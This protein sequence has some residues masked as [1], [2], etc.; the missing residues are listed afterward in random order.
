MN[1]NNPTPPA[2][3]TS[4]ISDSSGRSLLVGKAQIDASATRSAPRGAPILYEATTGVVTHITAFQ[5]A[6][7]YSGRIVAVTTAGTFSRWEESTGWGTVSAAGVIPGTIIVFFA[8]S[9][10]YLFYGVAG[11]AGSAK[12]IWRSTDHGATW[13]SVL[14]FGGADDYPSPI[15]ED[16]AGNLYAGAYGAGAS[17]AASNSRSLWKSTDGGANWSDISA[18]M[19]GGSAGIDRHIHGVWW[20]GH[21]SLLFVTHGDNGSSS[22]IYVSDD[23]GATFSTWTASAQA[24]AMAFTST[25]VLYAAD[26]SADR[27]VYRAEVASLAAVIASTP[28]LCLDWTADFSVAG[29]G[30][31]QNGFAWASYE[32]EQGNVA[33]SF[34]SEGTRTAVVASA[35]SGA[36]WTQVKTG[37]ASGRQW[38]DFARVSPYNT[39]RDGFCYSQDTVPSTDVLSQ[40]R[41][42]APET[43]L[44]VDYSATFAVAD[45]LTAPLPQ[46]IDHGLSSSPVVQKLIADYAEPALVTMTN[47]VIDPAGF[48]LGAATGDFP[49]VAETWDSAT[50]PALPSGWT[51]NTSGTGTAAVTSTTQ[52]VSGTNSLK[53]VLGAGS[54]VSQIRKTTAPW[55]VAAGDEL[56]CAASFWIDAIGTT[57]TDLIE[58]NSMRIGVIEREGVNRLEVSNTTLF[59]DYKQALAAAL[60]FPESAWVRVKMRLK[61]APNAS[62]QRYGRVQVWQDTGTGYRMVLDVIGASTYNS[63]SQNLFVG[64]SSAGNACTIYVDDVRMGLT[65]PERPPAYVLTGTQQAVIGSAAR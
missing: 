51:T 11:S 63:L 41:L 4:V 24:T 42:Y 47:A 34:G 1:F 43:V 13:T 31:T 12:P 15:C 14:T 50:A 49:L 65:D 52:A 36:T 8:D 23:A 60:A 2:P 32:D 62:S 10:G 40:W 38:H 20:D 57:R 33:F 64:G 53:C 19:P 46:L 18:N 61:L 7:G 39:G 28:T 48:T 54:A 27:R 30:S 26:S 6:V 55:T 59:I 5:G 16:A 25:H 17:G 44:E 58:C 29:N 21:R 22:K 37:A 35:D 56:W 9:R 45:G 3:E